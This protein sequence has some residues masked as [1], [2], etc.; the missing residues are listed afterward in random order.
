MKRLAPLAAFGAGAV[1]ALLMLMAAGV[2][3]GVMAPRWQRQASAAQQSADATAR[4]LRHARQAALTLPSPVTAQAAFAL[5]AAGRAR[6]RLADL[7]QLAQRHG[8]QVV[9][10][11]QRLVRDAR[12]GQEHWAVAMPAQARYDDLRRFLEAAL[13][14][15]PALALSSLRLQRERADVAL[16]QADLQWALHQ[17]PAAG[18]G[19]SP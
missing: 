19:A 12:Q 8:V 11:E 16:L 17:Q 9:H 7:L 15:D 3:A 5:P 13:R 6:Q 4:A 2:L 10:T 1:L 18:A 14:A